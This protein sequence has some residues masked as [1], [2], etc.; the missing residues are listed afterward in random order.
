[1][2]DGS[3]HFNVVAESLGENED[4]ITEIVFG[5]ISP[6]YKPT[7]YAHLGARGLKDAPPLPTGFLLFKD[8]VFQVKT[9]A[10]V[11]GSHLTVFRIASANNEDEFGKLHVLHL[12]YDMLSPTNFSWE[13]AT[14]YPGG[15]QEGVHYISKR[16]YDTVQPDFKSKRIAGITNEFGIF[17]IALPPESEPEPLEPFPKVTLKVTSSPEPVQAGEQ[18]THTI[19]F[20]NEGTSDAAEVNFKEVLDLLEYVSA[21]SSQGVCKQKEAANIIVCHL[22]VLRGKTSATI[23]I[24]ARSKPEWESEDITPD[25]ID[26]EAVFKQVATDFVDER[27]QIFSKVTTTIVKKKSPKAN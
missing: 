13:D 6:P 25:V 9:Q 14:V 10:L 12:N 1:M 21:S 15:W 17:A 11:A 19:T 5:G 26:L 20:T 8:L 4:G 7:E 22:G 27:G 18:V 2:V 24:V 23:T 3:S 16:L